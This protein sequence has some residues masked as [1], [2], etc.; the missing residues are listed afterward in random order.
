MLERP[1]RGQRARRRDLASRPRRLLA[2]LTGFVVAGAL[3]SSCGGSD[4]SAPRQPDAGTVTL[5]LQQTA[6]LR[7]AAE[8]A[9]CDLVKAPIEGQEHAE[10]NFTPAD[11][12][13]N[14]PTSGTHHP[15]WYEDGIYEPGAAPNLGMQVH[16]LEHGRVNF[17]YRAGSSQ[18]VVDQLEA[19][20]AEN[21]G[22][23]TLLYENASD[24]KYAVAATAWGRLLG[25]SRVSGETIDALRTFRTA[26]IDKGPEAVP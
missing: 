5:P 19:V 24:M 25:C 22:Y 23:H 4:E 12:K 8:A 7:E 17:Q 1:D 14:P 15:T 2:S 6:D 20:V 11:Y 3:L 21:E 26:F 18:E 13:S 9:G 16:S 10:K